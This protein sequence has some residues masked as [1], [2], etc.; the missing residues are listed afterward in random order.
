MKLVNLYHPGWLSISSFLTYTLDNIENQNDGFRVSI[1]FVG[2][3]GAGKTSVI[4]TLLGFR[5][6][7]PSSNQAAATAVPCVIA[8]DNNLDPS[9]AFES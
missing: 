7:L 5:D 8:Y 4:D 2:A 9:Q 1:G 6:L 3:T